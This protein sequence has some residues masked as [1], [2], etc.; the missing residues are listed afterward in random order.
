MMLRKAPR[1]PRELIGKRINVVSSANSSL[2]GLG[3]VVV[4]ETKQ[5]IVVSTASGEK[6]LLKAA[7]VLSIDGE[8][9]DGRKLMRR[10][11][12]R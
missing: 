3:G 7:V 2:E 11:E 1:I 10:P 6:R 4:D 9:V 5:S 12:D 8:R